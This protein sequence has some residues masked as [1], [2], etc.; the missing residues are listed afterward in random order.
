MKSELTIGKVLKP[1]GLKG[2]LKLELYSSNPAR[3]LHLKKLKIDDCQYDVARISVE[4]NFAYCLLEGIDSAEKAE[5]LR[6]KLVTCARSDLPPLE[7][8]EHYIVDMIGLDV[9]ANGECVGEI[10]DVLQYGSA[11]VYVVRNGAASLS[12]P[13]IGG[14]IKEVDLQGGKMMLD[15]TIF[16]RV[17]VFN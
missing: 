5:S 9:F 1:R 3:F 4:A 11:D 15:G 10:T 16:N 17:V 12:F 8:G 2:E 6:G 13:A 14:L 7:E